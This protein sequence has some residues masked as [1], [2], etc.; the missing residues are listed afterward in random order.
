M[1]QIFLKLQL[2]QFFYKLVI[3]HRQPSIPATLSISFKDTAVHLWN[4]WV[5]H[6]H[7]CLLLLPIIFR[8]AFDDNN[9]YMH[10]VEQTNLYVRQKRATSCKWEDLCLV[11]T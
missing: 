9:L 6:N 10:I 3:L 7:C 8:Q 2:V 11:Y 5:L 4:Q 1:F